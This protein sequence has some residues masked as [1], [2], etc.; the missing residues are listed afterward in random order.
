MSE[1]TIDDLIRTLRECAGEDQDTDLEGDIL[2]VTF[3]HLGYDSLA[4]L[5]TVGRIERDLSISL[6]DELIGE[7]PTPRELLDRINETA[8]QRA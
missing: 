5:N 7:A 8:R 4:L 6:P 2:D 3:D 1:F